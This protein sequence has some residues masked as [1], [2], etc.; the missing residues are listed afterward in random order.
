MLIKTNKKIILASTSKIRKKILED[1]SV[2]FEVIAPDFDEE[3]FKNNEVLNCSDL[4]LFLA[5]QKALSISK[6]YQDCFVIGSDQVCEF[7]GE[8]ISKSNS[9]DSAISQLKMFNSKIHFQNN[10]V[11]VALNNSVIFK[12]S[13]KAMMHMRELTEQEILCY[14]NIDRPIGCAGSYKYESLGKHLFK[15]VEGDY[16]SILGL[17]IQGLIDFFHNQKIIT[18]KS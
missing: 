14:V 15:K 12:D 8:N 9:I 17:S 18:F 3:S 1:L 11:I 6:K 2:E 4:A 16:Y 5:T 10:A 13:S 7:E